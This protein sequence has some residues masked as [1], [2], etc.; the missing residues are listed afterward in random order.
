MLKE[1]VVCISGI[2]MEFTTATT[3][4]IAYCTIEKLYQGFQIVIHRLVLQADFVN[5][6][7][8]EFIRTII[9]E[10]DDYP[11]KTIFNSHTKAKQYANEKSI[12]ANY[13][14]FDLKNRI[15]SA[16]DNHTAMRRIELF[17]SGKITNILF[18][19]SE[20]LEKLSNLFNKFE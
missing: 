4:T 12:A 17:S 5:V 15:N 16:K 19:Y 14:L 8:F 2:Q 13:V 7:D 10:A 3:R 9:Q 6:H 11:L 1:N 18:E 20:N